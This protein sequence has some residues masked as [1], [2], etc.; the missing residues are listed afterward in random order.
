MKNKHKIIGLIG[1]LLSICLFISAVF[2]KDKIEGP[3]VIIYPLSCLSAYFFIG[4]AQK[5]TIESGL[6]QALNF[7]KSL[8][9]AVIFGLLLWY[10]KQINF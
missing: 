6:K 9:F 10:L 1:M 7:L 8:I 3:L 5:G 4:I 2:W